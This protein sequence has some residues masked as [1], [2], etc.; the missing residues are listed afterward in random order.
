MTLLPFV[1][2]AVFDVFRR[3]ILIKAAYVGDMM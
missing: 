1:I 3:V 2:V